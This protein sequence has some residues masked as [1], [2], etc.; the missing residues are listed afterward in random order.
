[1]ALTLCL[2]LAGTARAD[3]DLVADLNGDG[4]AD[5][6]SVVKSTTG[7]VDRLRLTFAG[8]R[9]RWLRLNGPVR[10][11]T[12]ADIDR[13]GDIDLVATTD[14]AELHTWFNRGRGRFA[15]RV[16][17]AHA[18]SLLA[19]PGPG[20]AASVVHD[21][22]TPAMGNGDAILVASIGSSLVTARQ[23]LRHSTP[24]GIHR[25]YIPFGSRAPP[26]L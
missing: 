4:R 3:D 17:S 1:V 14:G 21:E 11:V 9:T 6:V 26:A 2:C 8:G 18:P 16:V 15:H 19:R 7:D 20:L 12:A 23:P 24:A 10:R 13:D 22:T 25:A 5:R